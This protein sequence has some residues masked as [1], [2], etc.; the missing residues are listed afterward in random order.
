MKVVELVILNTLLF[1]HYF[2]RKLDLT[3]VQGGTHAP[4]LVKRKSNAVCFHSTRQN[5]QDAPDRQAIVTPHFGNFDL[6]NLVQP[7]YAHNQ[8]LSGLG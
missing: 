5:F 7:V 3:R 4:K 1:E 6:R 8:T 2:S